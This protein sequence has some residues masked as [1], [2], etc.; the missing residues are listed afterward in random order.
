MTTGPTDP[1]ART[2]AQ[3]SES[4][5]RTDA[6]DS[7]A[8]RPFHVVMTDRPWPDDSIERD[9][10]EAAG[11]TLELAA[12]DDETSLVAAVADADALATCWAKVT[13]AVIEAA[14]KC[15]HIARMGIGLDNID[16][17]AATQRGIPVTNV[18]DYCIEEV[19]DHAMA[20]LL[21]LA[22]KTAFYDR[23]LAAG[24]YDVN[25]GPPMRRLS[26]QTL[27]LVGLGRCGQ[28]M[29]RRAAGFGF[30]MLAWTP[31]GDDRGLPVEMVDLE[32]LT[33]ESDFISLHVPLTDET[34]HLFAAPQFE[35]MRNTA[36]I[37][38]TARG[39]VWDEQALLQAIE[40]GHIAGAGIDVY[41]PEPP[42]LTSPLLRHDR[43]VTTPHAA[44]VS[45]EALA[46]LR[47]RVADQIVA[48]SR[49]ERPENVV[50]D[51]AG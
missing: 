48:V 27:G 41:S 40:E 51:I 33:R 19:G 13:P 3:S 44:F 4:A 43:I 24:E 30:R 11:C 18:P 36:V 34:H 22:R 42:D 17:A 37:I 32:T 25:A 38:N 39:P 8:E 26:R 29:A 16:L 14:P 15:V 31:S 2:S 35:A 49:K 9:R 21:T 50:N 5:S 10:L 46:E 1:T 23:Q 7:P 47:R 28:A 6:R 20:L 45:V 12:A